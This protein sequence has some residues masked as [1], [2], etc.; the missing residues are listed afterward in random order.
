MSRSVPKS[1]DAFDLWLASAER[2]VLL[3][4]GTWMRII[5]PSVRKLR[6]RN[7]FPTE[8]LPMVHRFENEGVK[9]SELE[10]DELDE[11][12]RMMHF[13]IAEM[14]RSILVP[15][16]ASSDTRPSGDWQ[17]VTLHGSDLEEAEIDEQDMSSLQAIAIRSLTPNQVTISSRRDRELANMGRLTPDEQ[18]EVIRRRERELEVEKAAAAAIDADREE[19][20]PGWKSFRGDEGGDPTRQDERAVRST[21]ERKARD[22]RRG[23]RSSDR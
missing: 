4:T 9:F 15:D 11:F 19:T 3:P 23:A 20:V 12:V 7:I 2:P 8:L 22:R 21:S 18:R 14:V 5:I 17:P 1:E 13:L 6:R 10:D 16:E